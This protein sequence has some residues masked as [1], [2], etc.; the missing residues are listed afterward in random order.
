MAAVDAAIPR[1]KGRLLRPDACTHCKDALTMPVRRSERVVTVDAAE[2][3]VF[4]LRFDLPLVRCGSCGLDQLPT[5]SQEDLTVVV[6]ALFAQAG[7]PR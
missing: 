4:T 3:P 7:T 1:A 6:P 5:R 2:G